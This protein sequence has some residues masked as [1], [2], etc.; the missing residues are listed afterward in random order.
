MWLPFLPEFP[1]RPSQNYALWWDFVKFYTPERF[2]SFMPQNWGI[3]YCYFLRTFLNFQFSLV[4]SLSHVQL[5]K[6]PWTACRMP[7]FSVHHQLLK[8]AQ[9]HLHW[10]S[11]AIQ[12]SHPLSSPSPPAFNLSQHKGLIQCVHSLHQVDKVLEFQLQHQ[13]LQWIFR[14]DF[15]LDWLVG[16]PCSP[17]DS[18]ESFP[19]LQFKSISSSA[20]SLLYT[21]TLTSI[22]DYWKNHSFD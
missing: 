5:F 10:V 20:L 6:T 8:L 7:G 17:R 16:F 3:L 19:T 1:G 21:P 15:L 13:S 11:D 4:Q 12:P 2:L 14:T 9:T 18:Q 22:H